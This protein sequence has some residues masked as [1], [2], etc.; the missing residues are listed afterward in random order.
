MVLLNAIFSDLDPEET[1]HLHVDA[2]LCACHISQNAARQLTQD[3]TAPIGAV[4]RQTS[5]LP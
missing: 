1:A 3:V 5:S 2:Q 4:R